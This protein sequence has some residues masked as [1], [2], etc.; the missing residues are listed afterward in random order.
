MIEARTPSEDVQKQSCTGC[1]G[2]KGAPIAGI[3]SVYYQGGSVPIDHNAE[4]AGESGEDRD[5]LGQRVAKVSIVFC[6][7]CGRDLANAVGFMCIRD[8]GWSK[9]EPRKLRNKKRPL[10]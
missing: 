9:L 8:G 1:A 10:P 5:R 2:T 3:V 7:E 4:R 6:E